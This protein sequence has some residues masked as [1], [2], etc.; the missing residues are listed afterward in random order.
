M[1]Q[2]R[3]DLNFPAAVWMVGLLAVFLQA[4]GDR[5]SIGNP[6]GVED[7]SEPLT[8]S[9]LTTGIHWRTDPEQA[10]EEALS[11]GRLV[12]LYWTAEWCPPCHDLK[13]NVFPKPSFIE[14]SRLFV[15]V[16]LDG[17]QLDAQEWGEKL[18]VV[19]YPTLV[20]L[21]SDG[22][23][24]VRVS[25]GMNLAAYE[26][27]LDTALSATQPM[28]VLLASLD[29][30]G[31]LS[32]TSCRRLAYHA[33]SSDPVY[34]ASGS[35]IGV[36]LLE[37]SQRCPDEVSVDSARLQIV[38]AA[39]LAP[40]NAAELSEG[41]AMH[42]TMRQALEHVYEISQVPKLADPNALFALK[43]LTDHRSLVDRFGDTE[44]V[45]Y[46]SPWL[47]SLERF[48]EDPGNTPF[49]R[50]YAIGGR[51]SILRGS[52]EPNSLP[53]TSVLKARKAVTEFLNE[54]AVG[55]DRS[56]IVL[57]AVFT[58]T[59][60]G[61]YDAAQTLLTEEI[62]QSR[63]PF[64]QMLELANLLEET[65]DHVRALD[66]YE[67]AYDNSKGNSTRVQ[68]GSLYNRAC[69]RLQPNGTDRIVASAVSVIGELQGADWSAR[70]RWAID[71][72]ET[73]LTDWNADG[74][75]D[76]ALDEI[77]SEMLRLC[78]TVDIGSATTCESFLAPDV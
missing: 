32:V 37:A 16:Y 75:H 42:S 55:Y 73:A 69:I 64:Y 71:S 6:T 4:C 3:R 1:N 62:T 33:W 29:S 59:T 66:W 57:S 40:S 12:M 9:D 34:L 17:D 78:G 8:R 2:R 52:E 27:V 72:M 35:E 51:L 19:G 30:P 22:T 38:A 20:V 53:E 74:E 21:N 36:K 10:F 63:T 11:S 77:R 28:D 76:E 24:I 56:A 45:D 61:D 39:L 67:K 5:A 47:E 31:D 49:T 58:L 70:V 14:K 18:G 26:E 48:A 41:R 46:I 23:E 15:P 54:D 7:D 13:E 25:G 44:C 68:W 50:L 43:L 60:L 65:G